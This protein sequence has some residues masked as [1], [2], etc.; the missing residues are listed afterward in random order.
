MTH[1]RL[2]LA[3]VAATLAVSSPALASGDF[4]CAPALR[5]VHGQ[6]TGCDDMAVLGPANDTRTNLLLLQLD[7]HGLPAGRSAPLPAQA[8]WGELA[9]LFSPPAK[10]SSETAFADGEGSRCRTDGEGSRR[11]EAAAT[12]ARDL[13]VDER[14]LLVAARRALKP[15]CMG[16][17]AGKAAVS[18][19]G[20]RVRSQAGRAYAA[21][22]TGASAFYEGDF[23]TA[24]AAF[25]AAAG[26]PSPWLQDAGAYMLAR[27]EVNRL[28]V[29]VFDQYG[30]LLGPEHVDRKTA[31]KA[32]ARLVAYARGHP[33]GAY[34]SSA[35]GLLRR[36]YWLSGRRDRLAA[37]YAALLAQSPASRG[38][39]GPDL[40]DEIDDKLLAHLAASETG[41]PTLL[42]VLDLRAMRTSDTPGEKDD[43][44]LA[45]AALDAQRPAFAQAPELFAYL[46]AV[47]AFYVERS[48][49][50]VLQ[51]LPDAVRTRGGYLWFSRQALRGM[52]LEAVHDRNA[53]GFWLELAPG[54]VAPLQRPA[55][56]LALAMHD[57][58]AGALARVFEPGS[59]VRV[60]T[61]RRVLLTHV[62]DAPLLRREAADLATPAHEREVARFTLLWKELTRGR[63]ADFVGDVARAPADASAPKDAGYELTDDTPPAV[64]IFRRRA[65]GELD[66]PAPASIAMAL[67]AAPR[68]SRP[69][70]CLAEFVRANGLDSPDLDASPPK[71]ELGG[72]P[73]LFDGAPYHR[74]D[75]Y[76]AVIADGAAPAADR[77]YALYRAVNCYGPSGI[78]RCG[79]AEAA[80]A[81]RKAW[82][83][84]LKH[85][86]PVSPWAQAL[87]YWW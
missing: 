8:S 27:T 58:R 79:G 45:A 31:E 59:Q 43:P 63:Y 40:A 49:T 61:Y 7:R 6:L 30:T 9:T 35:Q 46:Q 87:H 75:T 42:A 21:Y 76:R 19:A 32:E 72:T 2:W 65:R 67:A 12:T 48:P 17:G 54:A 44:P 34:V 10:A 25:S 37:A 41:D 70:L 81:Q 29:G 26:A 11:F 52:A 15:T 55:V 36:V 51:L 86:H 85:D 39:D 62:A 33:R 71:S 3:A 28:Q 56:E 69:R 5:L 80:P 68:A 4:E 18:E 82:F 23:D 57:E 20:S 64:E 73:T 14:A 13:P 22:L 16:P 83:T 78:N 47:H 24:S 77:A 60:P 84:Q 50:R 66:C 74:L 53:R 38:I 1:V